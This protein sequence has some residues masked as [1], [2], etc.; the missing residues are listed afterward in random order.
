MLISKS[1]DVRLRAFNH[2]EALVWVGQQLAGTQ[3]IYN[4][5]LGI[6]LEQL[7]VDVFQ[8]AFVRLAERFEPL[9]AQLHSTGQDVQ[10]GYAVPAHPLLQVVDFSASPDALERAQAWMAERAGKPFDPAGALYDSALLQLPERQ[11]IWFINQHHLVTDAWSCRLLLEAMD[12]E[13]RN[14]L[15]GGAPLPPIPQRRA[16]PPASTEAAAKLQ[17]SRE[18]WRSLY[19]SIPSEGAMFNR[20]G[21]PRRNDSTRLEFALSKAE[22][23]ELQALASEHFRALTP[24]LSLFTFFGVLLA[25]LVSR[26]AQRQR[27]AFDTPAL[28]RHSGD[29]RATPGLFIELFPFAVDVEA[30][31]SFV[32]L[33]QQLLKLV[34][35]FVVH[36]RP[37]ASAPGSNRACDTLLNFIP[38]NLGSFAGK[39]VAADFVHPGC[40]DAAYAIR[41]QVWDLVGDGGLN[42]MLDL[43]ND[44]FVGS[45]Q[46]RVLDCTQRLLRAFARNPQA[47]VASVPLLSEELKQRLLV[48]YNTASAAPIPRQTVL[49][50]AWHAAAANPDAVAVCCDGV[51][52]SYGELVRRVEVIACGFAAAGVAA[53]DRV[54]ICL[55]RGIPM[56]EV[57]LGLLRLGAVYVPVDAQSPVLR[58]QQIFDAAGVV[59]VVQDTAATAL[60]P[61]AFKALSPAELSRPTPALTKLPNLEHQDLHGDAYILFTSGSTGTPKGIPVSQLGLAV[62]IE[63][64]QRQYGD[65]GP[66]S[67]PLMSSI[68][69][70]LTVTSLFLPLVSGGTLHV[71]PS[72]HDSFDN[73][74]LRAIE[75]NHVN[76]IKLTPA[77]LRLLQQLD[78]QRSHLHTLI[79]GG[80]QL[81]VAIAESTIKKFG[82]ELRIFNEYGPTEAVVGCMIYRYPLDADTSLAG[83]TAVPI[84]RPADHTRIYLLN[85]ALQPVHPGVVGEIYVHRLGAPCAYLRPE[86]AR[87]GTF[88]TDLL[89]P[90]STMYKTG[91]LARFNA[92]GELVYLGRADQQVKL[93]GHR[94]E[95]EE[96]EAVLQSHEAIV[97]AV[98]SLSEEAVARPATIMRCSAC[99]VGDD[100]PGIHLDPEGICQLCRDFTA[101]SPRIDAYF[102]QRSELQGAIAAR[103]R[104]K[105]GEFD[106]LVLLSGGKDS[107]YALYQV[108]AMGFKIYAFT[109]DNGYIS[110]QAHA[111]IQRV[112]DDLGIA[113]EFASTE[114]MNE[115]FRDSL[116]RFSNVCQG[117]F[118]TIYTL[119]IRR[120]D[121]LG[122]PLVVTGLS[123]GQ[124]FETRLNLGLF[125]GE[126]SD[127]EIDSAVI[128]ARKAY[129]RRPDA[130][131][132]CLG[133][134]GFDGDELFE[135]VHLLDFYRYWSASLDEMQG[136]LASHAPWIRPSDTGRSSNCL[137]NDVGIHVHAQERGHHNYALPY[138]WDVRLQQKSREQ[139]VEEL[140]DDIDLPRVQRILDD[141][142]YQ[143]K[144]MARAGAGAPSLVAFYSAESAIDSGELKDYLARRL[145]DFA[146]PAKLLAVERMPLTING[147]IDRSAL[148]SL[149]S[150]GSSATYRAPANDAETAICDL[151]D[152]LLDH[153]P[154]GADDNFFELGGNSLLAIECVNLLCQRFQLS[155]PLEL[156]FSH[157]LAAQLA[158][159]L[160]QALMAEINQLSDDQVQGLL[161]DGA[162][163]L[164]G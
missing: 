55:E 121:E 34:P 47:P 16:A 154:I 43:K 127:Q 114:H 130:V 139:A 17:K 2:S 98:V 147:K 159:A 10:F 82:N 88:V 5:A 57:I 35:G 74:L 19:A 65:L 162:S 109:L 106:C 101:L 134:E 163:T 148:L 12:E 90:R 115:I 153:R 120:A 107:T 126:R 67:M 30:S 125:R 161:D 99:G 91:D 93:L 135:R 157:P 51:S 59:A 61:I 75:D 32:E 156:V 81:S 104:L 118:K 108:A 155:L 9:Q 149:L 63:W 89:D 117:C 71:Y 129:H 27:I 3:P 124:L 7:A 53:G 103:A 136:F 160:E 84:G 36:G 70:D 21:D 111:N 76:A 123:R 85:A 150:T 15:A 22:V 102:R 24:Q 49:Q 14:L 131:T 42:I 78:V 140:S 83:E 100:T 40:S 110:E 77:H 38:F 133:T 44:V 96:I 128:A 94:V 46:A 137:I 97:D 39:P 45:D 48:D 86:D 105:R 8:R 20:G 119:S 58:R 23:D 13:Y 52:R 79:V 31:T 41:M 11:A 151:W 62:Y 68:A 116:G 164:G 56:V 142:G 112:V 143:A 92:R 138:S 1:P 25:S 69:F 146:L 4:M 80:E 33:G 28:N 60:E 64:A 72:T 141:I 158:L 18:Y 132:Q 50:T 6:R 54:G 73:A 113:H 87:S 144:P 122:I 66:L 145:P 152:E 95:L 29:D 26:L 37:G